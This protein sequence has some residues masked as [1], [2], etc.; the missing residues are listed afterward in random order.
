MDLSKIIIKSVRADNAE[1]FVK[2]LEELPQEIIRGKN[3]GIIR[4][5]HSSIDGTIELNILVDDMDEAKKITFHI[6]KEASNIKKG[7]Y[8]VG[9]DYKDQH[10]N[11]RLERD[12][13]L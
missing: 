8:W 5:Y 1:S 13:G 3:S 4:A 12:L 7:N 10:Y 2:S 11:L 6:P 9:F